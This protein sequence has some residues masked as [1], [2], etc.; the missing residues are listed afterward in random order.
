MKASGLSK[1][2]IEAIV[3]GDHADPF[4]ALGPHPAA[5][6][7]RIAAFLPGAETVAVIGRNGGEPLAE[8]EKIHDDGLFQGVV[9]DQTLSF[10][11]RLK[12]SRGGDTWT[13]EDPYRFA[14][15]I[16]EMDNYLLGEGSH[17][18]LWE[19]L[20]AH[21]I[22][23][24]GVKGTHFAVWAPNARR[25][26][27]VGDF[28]QWDGRRHPMRVHPG[29]GVWEIFLPEVGDGTVYKYE[30]RAQAG[31][32]LPLKAD[33]FAFGSELRP[34]TASVV[35]EIDRFAWQDEDWLGKRQGC[36]AT[37]APISIYE[38]HLGSWQRGE[39]GRFLTYDELADRLVAYVRDMGFTHI[40]LLPI[41]EHPFDGSWGYQPIGL[42]A[43]TA[44]HGDPAGFA[45]FVD[46][47]HQA[48]IGVLLDWVPGHFPTD[49]HGLGRFDG[50]ALYEHADP[51]QGF[52][53]DWNTLIY[54]YGRPEVANYL[55]ANALFWLDRY[56]LD[57]LRVDAVASM[58]YLDYSREDGEWVPNRF[59][60]REN[61]EA[62]DLLKRA[63]E[64][65]YGEH[66]GV[67]TVAE[68]STAW[69]GVSKPT[70]AGGLGFGYKWNMGW[71]HDTL[72]YMGKDPI[73]RRWHHHQ[74]T[75]GLLYAFSENF[76]LPLSH[77]EVVHGKGSI[78]SRM[79]G[80]TW[81]QFANIRAY[82][83]FMWG[84][85]GKKLLFMGQDFAQGAEWNAEKALDWHLLDIGWHK[86]V[87]S[88]VKDLNR[89]YRDETALHELD[90]DGS[91]FE[92]LEANDAEASVFAWLRKGREGAAPVLVICNLTPTPRAGYRLGLPAPGKWKE[93]LNSDAEVYGGSGMGNQGV[94]ETEETGSHDRPQS[95]CFDLPPLATVWFRLERE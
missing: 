4:A 74:L 36:T 57:G 29:T 38:V 45:R 41:T 88:L 17:K 51:R 43:P 93:I 13:V 21:L 75:F 25:V 48:G 9:E 91:G 85:P 58:L 95:A 47:C 76:V 39:D 40:E 63:N 20:G 35:R 59:G 87:Q 89:L 70:F 37:D 15:V 69:P 18:R 67:M 2:T 80:D 11:Y 12:A 27:V 33:P 73:H 78:L 77:D 28:N 64:L 26:S 7:V 30:I 72:L 22:E 16:G 86:G 52:H 81:Q 49:E 61:L 83:A 53:Q 84:H 66:P 14:P 56:H 55:H 46:R 42:F 65:A 32:L 82:Y 3:A 8:L 1:G 23:H 60:G 24:Q 54:N 90:C 71:M 62:I 5:G 6:G 79:P 50:T 44:R 92:W 34:N 19:R 68:E 10:A 31:N 94:I